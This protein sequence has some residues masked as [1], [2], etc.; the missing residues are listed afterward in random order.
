MPMVFIV[1]VCLLCMVAG[2]LV[3]AAIYRVIRGPEQIVGTAKDIVQAV[4][5]MNIERDKRPLYDYR[6]EVRGEVPNEYYIVL[7]T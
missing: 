6:L 7:R 4:R 5:I 1:T 3:I 2:L